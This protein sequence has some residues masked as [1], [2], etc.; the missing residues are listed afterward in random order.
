MIHQLKIKRSYFSDILYSRK[1]FEVRKNDRG[2]QTGDFLGLNEVDENN[3]ETGRC[4]LVRVSDVFDDPDYCK[5][6]YVIMSIQNINI[7]GGV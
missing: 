1:T 3:I 4:M 5:D 7:I 2:F 6:G